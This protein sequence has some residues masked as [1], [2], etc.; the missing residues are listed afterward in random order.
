MAVLECS[1][2]MVVSTAGSQ[3]RCLRCGRILVER[4]QLCVQ[5]D[6]C[7]DPAASQQQPHDV[8]ANDRALGAL[9]VQI[10]S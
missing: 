9:S 10:V 1:C 5:T 7:H 6:A 3:A 8:E 4:D 2:G